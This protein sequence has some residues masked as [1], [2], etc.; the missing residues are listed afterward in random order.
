MILW[1]NIQQLESYQPSYKQISLWYK[2]DITTSLKTTKNHKMYSNL[3]HFNNSA[4]ITWKDINWLNKY[5]NHQE[6][7]NIIIWVVSVFAYIIWEANIFVKTSLRKKYKNPILKTTTN[8]TV[9]IKSENKCMVQYG[10]FIVKDSILETSEASAKRVTGGEKWTQ[11][12]VCT[13]TRTEVS[14]GLNGIEFFQ[15]D[16]FLCVHVIRIWIFRIYY[17]VTFGRK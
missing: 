15:K 8:N 9:Y 12:F 2:E 4:C 7:Q 14:P 5:Q 16:S 6:P 10:L 1:Q 11:W 17:I 3:S 13:K